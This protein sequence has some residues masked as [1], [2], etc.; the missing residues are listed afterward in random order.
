MD[1]TNIWLNR[2]DQLFLI[3]PSFY[4]IISGALISAAINLLTSLV[5]SNE[6]RSVCMKLSILFLLV[7]SGFFIFIS[8]VL[9]H[10]HSEAK[11]K[12]YLLDMIENNRK[13][14]YASIF[15]GFACFFISILF[16][17]IVAGG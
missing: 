8:L 1:E 2:I 3:S 17:I 7:S 13:R 9:E 11:D 15:G 5:I 4:S 14:L 16:L 12:D 10:L 6:M